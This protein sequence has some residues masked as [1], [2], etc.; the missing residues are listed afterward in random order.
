MDSS[1]SNQVKH[2]PHTDAYHESSSQNLTTH[3]QEATQGD[4]IG[5]T[6]RDNDGSTFI[7]SRSTVRPFHLASPEDRSTQRSLGGLD[8]GHTDSPLFEKPEVFYEVIAGDHHITQPKLDAK[9]FKGFF[10]VNG[11]WTTYRRTY[12]AVKCAVSF[13]RAIENGLYIQCGGAELQRIHGFSVTLSATVHGKDGEVHKLVHQAPKRHH[14][15]E[16]ASEGAIWFPLITNA[17]GGERAGR[18]AE[19]RLFSHTFERL[20]FQKGTPNSGKGRSQQKYYN[21]VVELHAKI[22][23]SEIDKDAHWLKIARRTSEPLSIRG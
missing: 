13:P 16:V 11:R 15:S 18:S 6:V 14:R 20:Q 23:G 2:E 22:S 5:S 1:F 7:S 9:I 17:A 4:L 19:S 3:G 10:D 12:F 8:E 21:L